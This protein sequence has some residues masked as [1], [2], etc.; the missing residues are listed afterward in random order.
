MKS[1]DPVAAAKI[2][3]INETQILNNI[4]IEKGITIERQYKIIGYFAD[5]YDKE[6]NVVYEVDEK[7]HLN[8]KE[9]ARDIQRQQNIIN[10]LGCEFIRIEDY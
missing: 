2:L 8:K 6:N 5:G 4:E 3:D 9:K 10:E 1:G 7:H